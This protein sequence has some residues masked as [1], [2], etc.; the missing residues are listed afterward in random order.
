M[1]IYKRI[2]LKNY[3]IFD[4]EYNEFTFKISKTI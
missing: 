4:D 3:K 2:N 1:T